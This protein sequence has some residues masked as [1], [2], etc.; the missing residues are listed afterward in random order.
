MNFKRKINAFLL[1]KDFQHS[2]ATF[3]LKEKTL[4]KNNVNMTKD[5]LKRKE[6][7]VLQTNSE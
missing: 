4:K 5:I 3:K 7:I 6:K 1:F 2:D